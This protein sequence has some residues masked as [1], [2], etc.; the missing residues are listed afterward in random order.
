[1]T[2]QPTDERGQAG[3]I[4]ALA[5]GLLI[6]V[7]GTLLV[8][9]TWAVIDAKMAVDAAAREA[10]RS[11]VEARSA[12]AAE[13]AAERAGREAVAA[14]GRTADRLQLQATAQPGFERCARVTVTARYPV[15]AVN[16]PLIGGF[17]HRFW[18]SATH[19]ELVDPFAAGLPGASAC[20]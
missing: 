15:P 4:E 11:Y 8:A 10:A 12:T 6:F 18:V 1:M 13:L 14:Q 16:L 7:V 2:L 3:G 9:N 17:G 19:S 20:G 5:F